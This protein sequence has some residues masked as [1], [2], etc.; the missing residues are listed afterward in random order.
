MKE[1]ATKPVPPN[2]DLPV[3]DLPAPTPEQAA[4]A[5]A[6]AVAAALATLAAAGYR[7][8][9][10]KT[11]MKQFACK[12]PKT[13]SEDFNAVCKGKGLTVSEVA[14]ALIADWVEKNR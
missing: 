11:E 2:S 14:N 12:V 3:V 4:A 9:A 6:A 8:K 5:H 13:V 10:P 7:T 1:P